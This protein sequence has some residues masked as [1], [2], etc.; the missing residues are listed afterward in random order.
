MDSFTLSTF[1]SSPQGGW[2]LSFV[3]CT[4]YLNSFRGSGYLLLFRSYT[5]EFYRVI[6]LFFRSS[7]RI[8]GFFALTKGRKSGVTV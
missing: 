3:H 1:V 4:H 7:M 5:G 6:V 2:F 8:S